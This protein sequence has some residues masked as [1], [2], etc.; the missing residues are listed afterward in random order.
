[1]E[2]TNRKVKKQSTDAFKF[3]QMIIYFLHWS[4]KKWNRKVKLWII[5]FV[6]HTLDKIYRSIYLSIII[7]YSFIIIIRFLTYWPSHTVMMGVKV[8]LYDV[9]S[10]FFNRSNM[11]KKTLYFSS[12]IIQS[13]WH[14]PL[15][16]RFILFAHVAVKMESWEEG[17]N[18]WFC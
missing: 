2:K 7:N 17:R 8:P 16:F 13:L 9:I 5:L 14:Y 6:K 10:C 1:M 18:V 12:F 3:I 11:G 15:P 4:T